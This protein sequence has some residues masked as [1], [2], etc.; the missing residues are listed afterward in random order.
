MKTR[1]LIFSEDSSLK[2][3]RCSSYQIWVTSGNDRGKYLFL[4]NGISKKVGRSDGNDLVLQDDAV[5]SFHLDVQQKEKEIEIKDGH[6]TNGTY[7]RERDGTY[8]D[9][10]KKGYC[11]IPMGTEIRIGQTSL[12]FLSEPIKDLLIGK[13]P[14]MKEAYQQ[15]QSAAGS[16]ANVLILGETGVGKELAAREIHWQSVRFNTPLVTY[17]CAAS[18]KELIE[19]ELFG[20]QKGAFTGATDPRTGL[21]ELADNGTIFLDEIGELPLDLQPKLLRVLQEKTVKRVGGDKEIQLDFRVIAATNR[22]LEEEVSK[23]RFR[24]DLFYRLNVL[25]VSIPPLRERAE[26]IPLLVDHFC[27]RESV[28]IAPAAI[29]KLMAYDWPGNVRELQNT[30]ERAIA[31]RQG[32]V[33]EAADLSL[34]PSDKSADTSLLDEMEKQAIQKML[35]TYPDDMKKAAKVLGISLAKLYKR[36]KLYGF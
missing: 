10:R 13:S 21:F 20:H 34:Q 28:E 19:S 33:I 35:Q 1:P 16:D 23:G 11:K 5:S 24:R 8:T 9:I 2:R 4:E 29:E 12:R 27:T 36:K 14:Q 30:L 32:S 6:S 17:N 3:H 15:I 31:E 25:K 7:I 26:D 22:H 18:P